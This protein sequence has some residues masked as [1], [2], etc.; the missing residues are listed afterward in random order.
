MGF[1]KKIQNKSKHIRIQI[2]WI[3]VILFMVVILFFW[4]NSLERNL[5]GSQGKPE[6]QESSLPSVFTVIK[7]DISVFVKKIKSQTSQIF[8]SQNNK[9]KFEVEILE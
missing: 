5:T 8:D 3:S 7:K 2:L 4:L 1:I 9:S 6:K